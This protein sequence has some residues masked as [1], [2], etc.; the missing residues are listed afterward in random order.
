MVQIVLLQVEEVMVEMFQF[1][2]IAKV[3]Q[4]I[5]HGVVEQLV[6][7]VKLS[8]VVQVDEL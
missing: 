5:L 2:E 4:H 1:P 7:L 8:E 3:V 6:E